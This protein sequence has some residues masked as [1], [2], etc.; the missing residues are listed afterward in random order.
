LESVA[1]EEAVERVDGRRYNACIPRP[2]S[3]RFYY[4]FL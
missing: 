1:T 4:N 2:D 3:M